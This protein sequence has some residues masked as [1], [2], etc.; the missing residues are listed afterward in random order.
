M[1][2]LWPTISHSPILTRWDW[3]PLIQSAYSRNRHLFKRFPS[4]SRLTGLIDTLGLSGSSDT[5]K[6][7]LA[8]HVRRGDFED[9]CRNL[10]EW[11]ADWHA[12]NA[13]PEFID[14]F[15]K[16][17]DMSPEETTNVYLSHCYP[18]IQQIADKV[19]RVRQE[20]QATHDLRY[21]YIMTNGPSPW[22]EE[23]KTVLAKESPWESVKSSRDL[24]LTWE[25]KFVAQGV[26]M[27]VAQRAEVIIGNGV[28]SYACRMYCRV[29]HT[30]C[31]Y[32]NLTY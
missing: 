24:E 2:P 10:A 8:I 14:K 22:V 6:G 25:E 26:D 18:T 30:G 16:P 3:S 11:S 21:L 12:W 31:T 1:L 7:L 32:P 13:F 17:T 29:F 27:L 19:K 23:L 28:S 20:S 5:I 9:H 4:S 15:E